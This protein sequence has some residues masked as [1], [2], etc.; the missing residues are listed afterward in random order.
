MRDVGKVVSIIFFL[1]ILIGCKQQTDTNPV[2]APNPAP[3]PTS[4]PTQT[5]TP[6]ITPSLPNLKIHTSKLAGLHYWSGWRYRNTVYSG[7]ENYDF[8]SHIDTFSFTVLNDSTIVDG[9]SNIAA[10][11]KGIW[12]WPRNDSEIYYSASNYVYNKYYTNP[13]YRLEIRYNYFS[14][15]IYYRFSNDTG[16]LHG[17]VELQSQ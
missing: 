3:T 14:G 17:V 4:T 11:Y 13:S 15:V 8:H 7:F 9:R 16:V 2:P 1:G 6:T 5:P 12:L 10:Y